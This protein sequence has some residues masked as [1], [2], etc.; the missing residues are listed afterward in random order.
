M[1]DY[2]SLRMTSK[3]LEGEGRGVTKPVVDLDEFERSVVRL[4]REIAE[5]CAICFKD[6]YSENLPIITNCCHKMLCYD[7][8]AQTTNSTSVCPFCRKSAPLFPPQRYY[9]PL[10]SAPADQQSPFY[11]EAVDKLQTYI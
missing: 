9:V 11:K 3:I 2:I 7:C 8:L 10:S 4:Q 5:P 1:K 6:H